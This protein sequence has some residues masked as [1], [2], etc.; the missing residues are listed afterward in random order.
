MRQ[1]SHISQSFSR[2]G[3]LTRDSPRMGNSSSWAAIPDDKQ[4]KANKEHINIHLSLLPDHR[5]SVTAASCTCLSLPCHETVLSSQGPQINP[6]PLSCF[7]LD[8]RI[9][10]TQRRGAG[11]QLHTLTQ[12]YAPRQISAQTQL[13]IVL[14][15]DSA[16]LGFHHGFTL[17]FLVADSTLQMQPSL[18]VSQPTARKGGNC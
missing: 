10:S 7:L 3:G 2:V 8:D 17:R 12:T 14:A 1:T 15:K 16:S 5:S 4:E 13:G 6:P 9:Q 18:R 11:L